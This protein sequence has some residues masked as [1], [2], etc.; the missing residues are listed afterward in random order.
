INSGRHIKRL[1]WVFDRR[2]RT[3][4]DPPNRMQVV[5]AGV[6]VSAR[7]STR[8]LRQIPV[9]AV[10]QGHTSPPSG[11][12]A[13]SLPVWEVRQVQAELGLAVRLPAGLLPAYRP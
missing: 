9:L 10:A 2:I 8:R 5:P 1:L 3:R 6:Q 7:V 4:R 13:R 12:D 11:P